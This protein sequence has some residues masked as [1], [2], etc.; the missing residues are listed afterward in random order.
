VNRRRPKKLLAQS[1]AALPN[2]IRATMSFIITGMEL[3][4]RRISRLSG[5]NY[6]DAASDEELNQ[7]HGLR[8]T[9][10]N[11]FMSRIR[12]RSPEKYAR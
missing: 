11:E 10:G 3:R 2:K 12:L 8:L 1:S 7:K 4:A 5:R 9:I 6:R